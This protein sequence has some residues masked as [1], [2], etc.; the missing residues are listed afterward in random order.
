MTHSVGE[1]IL[2]A[3]KEQIKE[4]ELFFVPAKTF[5]PYMECVSK[6]LNQITI[7]DRTVEVNPFYKY[8]RIFAA[9]LNSDDDGHYEEVK[10]YVFNFWIHE[11][12]KAERL[13]GMTKFCFAYSEML[14]EMQ[15]TEWG[16]NIKKMLESF[17]GEELERV[18][19]NI[20]KLYSGGEY[21]ALFTSAL[22][23][24]LPE[25]YV[26]MLDQKKVLIYAGQKESYQMKKKIQSLQGIF[27][28]IESEM[29]IFW[30][31]H[32]GVFDI[33]GAMRLDDV[34]MV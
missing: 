13:E 1:Y 32:F 17:E 19:G 31:R 9:L 33:G 2:Y 25:A 7:D 16:H 18:A 22:K 21:F 34:L 23:Q 29:E 3:E 24:F 5:S 11:I 8:E 14:R 28:P 6:T 15:G 27:F 12:Y 10:Q 4:S 26:Y 30:D 20:L